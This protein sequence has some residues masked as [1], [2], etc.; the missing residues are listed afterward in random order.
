MR[1]AVALCVSLLAGTAAAHDHAAAGHEHAPGAPVA[2]QQTTD[3]AVYGAILSE[4][5]P[6]AVPIDVAAANPAEHLGKAGAYSG[7][8]TSV[9]Q[10][11]GCWLVLSGE[12]GEFARVLMHEHGFSVPKDARGEAVVYGTLA[13]KQRSA[14]EL[15]HLAKDGAK[16]A[17]ARELEI[18]ATSVVIRG[19]G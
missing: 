10:A 17:A 18:D 15:A 16:E 9:C 19:A 14:E 6:A 11:Q 1:F 4:A 3:G 8:I 2:V 12:Q 13:E 7:R 5:R